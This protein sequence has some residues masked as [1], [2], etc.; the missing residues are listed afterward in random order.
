MRHDLDSARSLLFDET[1]RMWKADL[2]KI[3]RIGTRGVGGGCNLSSCLVVL[4]GI[5]AFSKFFFYTKDESQGFTKFFDAY[6]PPLYRGKMQRIYKLFRN[7]LAHHYYPKSEFNLVHVSHIRFGVDIQGR[8]LPL[9]RF[10]RNLEELRSQW[11]RLDPPKGRAFVL[12]PQVL[13]LDTVAVMERLKKMLDT[14][15]KLQEQLIANH[16]R[17][18]KELR[19]SS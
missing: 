19:H 16:G 7:G 3:F 13:F 14:D 15:S 5:E 17:I 2:K 6:Y 9:S 10:K 8:V 1:Y 12:V 4:I 11:L 18:R